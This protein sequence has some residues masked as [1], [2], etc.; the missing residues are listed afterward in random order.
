MKIVYRAYA[1]ETDGNLNRLRPP[2][3][4]KFNCWKSFWNEFGG[5]AKITVVWDGEPRG[6]FYDY[7]NSFNPEIFSYPTMG[8][9]QSLLE[10]YKI[11]KQSKDSIKATVEDDFLILPGCHDVI[12][13]GFTFG[14]KMLTPYEHMDRY[15]LPSNDESWGREEIYLGRKN[16]WRSVESTTCTC[17]FDGG[18]FDNLYDKLV[19]YN[20]NDRPFFRDCLKNKI[21]LYSPMPASATHCVEKPVN[22]MS[23][24]IDWEEFSK[25]IVL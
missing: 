16:Y 12:K 3:F 7:I 8:N 2:W 6:Q 17:F 21:R 11:L 23:P 4:S 22:L 18:T 20:L 14:F 24:F 1:G 19:S 13:E 15:F 9:K 25:S 5:K 10:T